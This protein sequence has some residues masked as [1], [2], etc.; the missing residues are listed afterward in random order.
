MNDLKSFITKYKSEKGDPFTHTSMGSPRIALNIPDNK[1]IDFYKF[2]NIAKMKGENMH[3]TEKPLNPSPLRVDLDFRFALQKDEHQITKL[4]KNLYYKYSHI[5]IILKKYYEIISEI[6][7]VSIENL[8]VYI[9]E[10]NHPTEERLFVKDGIHFIFPNLIIENSVQHYIRKRL[11]EDPIILFSGLYLVNDYENVIDK[12]IIDNNNWQMYGSCKPNMQTYEITHIV[13]WEDEK[14]VEKSIEILYD[15]AILFDLVSKLSMRKPNVQYITIKKEKQKEIDEFIKI[16]LPKMNDKV[17]NIIKDALIGPNKNLMMKVEDQDTIDL[18]HKLVLDCINTNRAENFTDWI[19]L[20][21]ALRNIDHRL[22]DCWIEFSKNSSKYSQG[23]CAKIWDNMKEDSMGMGTL[24][25][26][27]KNDN[28]DKYNDLLNE[29][30]YPFIDKAIT[31]EGTHYDVALVIYKKYHDVYKCSGEK[32]WYR[33]E[34]TLHRWVNMTEALELN[35][36]ISTEIHMLFLD[37]SKYW[38]NLAITQASTE[39]AELY[40]SK[41]EKSLKIA[42][43]CKMTPYKINV[44]KECKGF[45]IED[46]FEELLDSK[47]HLL[48]FINGVYDF[49]FG[50]MRQGN[51]NDYIS[52]STHI[53]YIKYDENSKESLEIKDF[54]EKVFINQNVRKYFIEQSACAIDGSIRQERFYV[55][56]G[57]G[58]N[59]KSRLME[60]MQK[61]LGDYYCIMPISLLTNKRASSNSAQCELERTKGRR[62]A[63]MQEPNKEDKINVGLMKELSGNDTIQARTLFKTPIEFKPQFKMFLTC[64]KLP[65]VPS[66]DQGTWRRIRLIDFLSKFCDKPDKNI[67]NEFK[68][69]V[70]LNDKMSR[71]AET[72]ISMLIHIRNEFDLTHKDLI[73]PSEVI[74][75]TEK[76][77]NSQNIIAQFTEEIIKEDNTSKSKLSITIIYNEYKIWYRKNYSGTNKAIIDRTE[78]KTELEKIF[79]PY[80]IKGWKN[81]SIRAED[82]YEDED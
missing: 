58:S 6:L 61:C 72:F 46:K 34:K 74:A 60:M 25:W 57:S 15:P 69:D 39:H 50:I 45:F 28:P 26:W 23:E 64:N 27:A 75:A 70:Q 54:L 55:L 16:T 82:E 33:Y 18:A 62:F 21:W 43:K 66:S 1:L 36:K 19:Y 77:G 37:R 78:L 38:T 51:P 40:K 81:L 3:Y 13:S 48:G 49:K 71:W 42:Q 9:M 76:Y 63:V 79:G 73:E 41:A 7:N 14:L 59:G 53:K 10:K 22:L 12:A 44:L 17:R 24:R 4:D 31:S 11:L 52:F 32:S 68:I 47:P 29:T 8:E 30:I 65:D 20:G 67:T 35:G 5:E 2:Y 56:T 80:N